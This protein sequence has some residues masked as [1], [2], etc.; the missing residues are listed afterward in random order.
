GAAHL[1]GRWF[2]CHCTECVTEWV[3]PESYA[4][5]KL[6]CPSCGAKFEVVLE[7]ALEPAGAGGLTV[8]S[9]SPRPGLES[10]ND[11]EADADDLA[12]PTP[13]VGRALDEEDMLLRN[14]LLWRLLA[15]LESWRLRASDVGLQPDDL[16]A[17][18]EHVASIERVDPS[19]PDAALI[20]GLVGY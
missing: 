19:L 17:V 4:G 3:V 9:V 16:T 12:R 2:H 15:L 5:K 10:E 20:A 18:R 1:S 14:V 6:N 13:T 11:A 8:A 7:A